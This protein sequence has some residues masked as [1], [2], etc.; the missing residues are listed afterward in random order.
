[1]IIERKKE[2]AGMSRKKIILIHLFLWLFAGFANL[3][4]SG[5]RGMEL[6]FIVS[7]TIGFL[8]LMLVFYLFYFFLAPLF[9]NKRNLAGFLLK[10]LA[11][12]VIMPFFGY[13]L[14]FLSRA[15]FDNTFNDFFRGYSL[16]TH[17]SGFFPVMTAA[18]SGSFFR[19]II[20]WFDTMNQKI[21]SDRQRLSAELDLLKSKLNPHF[22]FNTLNNIDSL[23]QSDPEKASQSLIRLSDMM[24]YLTYETVSEKVPLEKELSYVTNMIELYRLRLKS[25]GKIL[26]DFTGETNVMIAPG[27]F[28]PVIE[29]TLKYSSFRNPEYK[30]EIHVSSSG[31]IVV[32]ET[33]NNFDKTENNAIGT[34]S[35]FGLA[36]LRRRLDLCY[37]ER[38]SLEI[39]ETGPVFSVMLKIDC[40]GDQLHSN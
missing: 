10:S 12:V 9:L 38:Y 3:P 6:K 19:V 14:L 13:L 30:T 32:L 2:I 23:I 20:N 4:F 34:A 37:N 5:L 29:N 16:K 40:N 1:M 31:G 26:Y 11:V 25:P 36:N 8:Y 39:S 18:L 28:I 15:I 33:S 22:L 21:E 7:Y 24:R 35:G 17:M 27:L